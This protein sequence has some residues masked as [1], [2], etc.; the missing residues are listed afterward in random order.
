MKKFDDTGNVE[1]DGRKRIK[2]MIRENND[3]AELA[4]VALDLHVSSCAISN[5][6]GVFVVEFSE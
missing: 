6:F 4:A 2:T 5:G 1:P 3:I